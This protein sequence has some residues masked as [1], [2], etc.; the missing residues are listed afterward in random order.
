LFQRGNAERLSI[1][2][3]LALALEREIKARKL[4]QAAARRAL[5]VTEPRINDLLG[6]RL[7]RFSIDKRGRTG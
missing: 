7:E 5:G 3:G 6:R 2:T 1:H 4:T